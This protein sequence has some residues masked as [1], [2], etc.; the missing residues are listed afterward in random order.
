M[1]RVCMVDEY[2]VMVIGGVK[3]SSNKKEGQVT[4]KSCEIIN[5]EAK[6][7]GNDKS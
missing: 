3:L 5:L 4:L 7:V 1:H 6:K 2:L